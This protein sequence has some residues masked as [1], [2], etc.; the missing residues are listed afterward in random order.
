VAGEAAPGGVGTGG[1]RA[2]RGRGRREAA[3]RLGLAGFALSFFGLAILEVSTEALFAFTGPVLAA[4]HQTRY[5][6]LGGLD[7]NLGSGLTAYFDLSYAVVVAGFLS[8]G[9]TFRADVYPRVG[10][11]IAIGSVAA[12]VM[13]PL[14]SVPAGPFRLDRIGVLAACAAFAW[15]GWHL[16]RHPA[17]PPFAPSQ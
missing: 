3:G 11:V 5:L 15:C 2:R 12:I 10:P 7:Q 6:L 17:A 14:A 9:M 8:F 16:L 4:H 13:A 1:G